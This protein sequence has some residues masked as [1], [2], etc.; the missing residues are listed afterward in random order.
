M[1][2][3]T[4]GLSISIAFLGGLGFPLY[5]GYRHNAPRGRQGFSAPWVQGV[6][7]QEP[8]GERNREDKTDLHLEAVRLINYN[9]YNVL[10]EG[11]HLIERY[12]DGISFAISATSAKCWAE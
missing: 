7:L 10:G 8:K 6:R 3:R 5:I 12:A 4:A 9:L 1:P 11:P 2:G